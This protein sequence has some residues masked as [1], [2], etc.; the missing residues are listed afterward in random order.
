MLPKAQ[1]QKLFQEN[2]LNY[3][4]YATSKGCYPAFYFLGCIYLE[5]KFVKQDP[6]KAIHYFA[7]GAARNDAFCYFEL[8]LIYK[9]GTYEEKDE[10]KQFRYLRHAAQEGLVHA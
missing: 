3:L 8:A 4:E 10:D 9:D 5:G 7:K 6:E 1:K 2:V